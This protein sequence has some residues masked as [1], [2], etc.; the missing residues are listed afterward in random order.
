HRVRV[1]EHGAGKTRSMGCRLRHQPPDAESGRPEPASRVRRR[2]SRV[3]ERGRHAAGGAVHDRPAASASSG[4][5][6][7]CEDPEARIDKGTPMKPFA[8]AFLLAAST[9]AAQGPAA[10]PAPWRGAGPTPC[11]GADG[12]IFSCPPAPKTLAI[13][14]GHLFDSKSG[15][16]LAN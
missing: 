4:V 13:R 10:P 1:R 5:R 7:V 12:G 11:V 6:G 15:Q 3:D 16:M 2:E 14:A 9:A 8:I